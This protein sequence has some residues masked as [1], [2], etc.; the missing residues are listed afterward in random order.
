MKKPIGKKVEPLKGKIFERI[1]VIVKGKRDK[2]R[3]EYEIGKGKSVLLK[4]MA[5]L[6]TNNPY[7]TI[8]GP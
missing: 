8:I 4:L 7:L 3:F 5:I 6:H 2:M 1:T